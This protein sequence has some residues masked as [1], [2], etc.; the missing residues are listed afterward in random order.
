VTSR[1]LTVALDEWIDPE[2]VFVAL[3]ADED[4]AF[5]LDSGRDA[6][7][8]VSF[9]GSA[10]P[11]SRVA[12]ASVSENAVTVRT[13]DSGHE[14]EIFA[15]SVFD[16]LR[17]PESWL[18]S[19][20]PSADVLES[21]D[22]PAPAADSEPYPLGWVGWFGYE[23]GADALAVPA[24]ATETPDA[25]LLWV[26]RLIAFDHRSR[27]VT[28]VAEDLPDAGMWIS[29]MLDRL[30]SID[31]V[32]VANPRPHSAAGPARWRHDDA[33]YLR[34]IDECRRAIHR[35]DAYQICLTNEVRIQPA[36]DP[37]DTYLRLRRLNETHHGGYLRFGEFA[38][39][40]S[41]PEQFLSMRPD[42]RVATRPIKGTRGR[43]A[44]PDSDRSLRAEL[45]ASDKER[46]ENIMIVD[47]MRNDLSRVC[48]P[49]S[50]EVSGLLEVETYPRVHQLVS[51]VSGRVAPDRT[52]VDVIEAC[53]PAGSMTGA[54]K[55]SAMRILHEIENGPRGVYAGC[56][57]YL[58]ADGALDLA[59]V[60]RSIVVDAEGVSIGTGGGI[61][62]L[63]EPHEELAEAKLKAQVMLEALMAAGVQSPRDRPAEMSR[64]R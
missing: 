55:I 59:M 12:L 2:L 16:Y 28:V 64:K 50:V 63:S 4:Y 27:C 24:R 56:F 22:D 41:S 17:R 39:L 10:S 14:R 60:I 47:L 58:S 46:A 9:L 30:R 49:G 53:F 31:S 8:G 3:F 51:T 36:P 33:A 40:S 35:G 37:F 57:G 42:G 62:A 45:T 11:A 20:L 61:T 5:W 6:P 43:G 13:A 19:A 18:G 7:G 26:D 44:T 48:R 1:K 52:A 15:G 21:D 23:A 38:L 32:P 29:G 34:M 25:A 54:P